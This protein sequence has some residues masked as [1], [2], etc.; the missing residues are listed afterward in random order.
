[1]RDPRRITARFARE[2]DIRVAPRGAEHA[3]DA[4]RERAWRARR[5]LDGLARPLLCLRDGLRSGHLMNQ[6]LASALAIWAIGCVIPTPLAPDNSGNVPPA[7]ISGDPEF[8][9]VPL[10]HSENDQLTLKINAVDANA[11]QL[12]EARL[13]FKTGNSFTQLGREEMARSAA[14]PTS[15]RATF[16]G[17]QVCRLGSDPQKLLY[18]F[19]AD[20]DFPMNFDPAKRPSDFESHSDFSYWVVVCT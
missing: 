5:A 13:F 8:T 3:D 9:A 1:M 2:A 16:D 15:H 7:I 18:I 12:L 10:V 11:D 14:D 6:C 4:R 19:V 17:I 20:T